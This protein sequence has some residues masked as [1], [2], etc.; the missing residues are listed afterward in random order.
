MK[1]R[2]PEG[3]GKQNLNAMM[4]QAQK[5]QEDMNALQQELKTREYRG[6]AGGAMVEASVN[7]E[8]QVLS[9]EIKPEVID[10]E[11]PEM[12]GDLVAAAV[13]AAVAA[14]KEDAQREMDRI[15]GGADLMGLV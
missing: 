6:A 2:L 8:Y 4:K 1:A 3:Y 9:V 10:P 5:M 14:A 11:D 13:N 15:T 12:L 7:G